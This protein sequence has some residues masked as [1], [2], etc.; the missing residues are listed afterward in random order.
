MSDSAST[1]REVPLRWR[2]IWLADHPISRSFIVLY[3]VVSVMCIC[4][5]PVAFPW[6]HYDGVM[7]DGLVT[8]GTIV[9]IK[10]REWA[11]FN[12]RHPI[13]LEYAFS[14]EGEERTDRM[15]T[16]DHESISEWEPGRTVTVK[17]LGTESMVTD[18]EPMEGGAWFLLGM[19]A[20]CFLAALPFLWW[21]L[22]QVGR[23]VRLYSVGVIRKG[24][25]EGV[26]SDPLS[27]LSIVFRPRF[28][29]TYSFTGPRGHRIRGRSLT[30]NPAF[31]NDYKAGDE[32]DVLCLPDNVL[33][34][35]VA[36]KEILD[37]CRPVDR[38]AERPLYP[39]KTLS[40]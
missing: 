15:T 33:T 6:Q 2:I 10:I 7:N 20:F 35:C 18:V 32:I 12:G 30:R 8:T 28:R 19:L 38:P 27:R 5:S 21:C 22:R 29:V 11:E 23:K 34:N 17:Y 14:A 40:D 16:L 31:V 37:S 25:F 3:L 24:Q 39:R 4:V 9:R 13:V 36:E 26:K 1:A